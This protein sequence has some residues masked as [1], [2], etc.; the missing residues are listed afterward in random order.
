MLIAPV[1]RTCVLGLHLVCST[2]AATASPTLPSH[3]FVI[4]KDNSTQHPL[5]LLATQKM[6]LS[7]YTIG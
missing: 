6:V 4:A 1:M 2:F 3:A 5:Q 7:V